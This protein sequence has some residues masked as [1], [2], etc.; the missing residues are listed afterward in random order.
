[1]TPTSPRVLPLALLLVLA[2]LPATPAATAATTCQGLE[3][4][5]RACVGTGPCYGAWGSLGATDFYPGAAACKTV[6]TDGAFFCGR[7]FAGFGGLGG[8]YGPQ[9]SWCI[10]GDSDPLV[11][12]VGPGSGFYD[13]LCL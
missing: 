6:A 1:M 5:P 2:I 7:A 12:C 13:P 10:L 4:G 9:A 3:S 8:F 11:L